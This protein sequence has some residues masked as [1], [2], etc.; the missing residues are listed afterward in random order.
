MLDSS[1][2]LEPRDRNRVHGASRLRNPRPRL[3][4]RPELQLFQRT[5][6]KR[7]QEEE[8]S[9]SPI[10][11]SSDSAAMEVTGADCP[12]KFHRLVKCVRPRYLRGHLKIFRKVLRKVLSPF[13]ALPPTPAQLKLATAQLALFRESERAHP[14]LHGH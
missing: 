4:V 10:R 14:P 12:V 9:G 8:A 5:K 1:T 2:T 7:L 3:F 13:R 6:A 11:S